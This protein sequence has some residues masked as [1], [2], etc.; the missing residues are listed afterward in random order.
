MKIKFFIL[1]VTTVS[2]SC[3]K[4]Q[5]PSAF[6]SS[7]SDSVKVLGCRGKKYNIRYP[8]KNFSKI[9]T[10]NYTEGFFYAI[11][12]KDSSYLEFHCGSAVQHPLMVKKEYV[13]TD[14]LK[15]S[16]YIKLSGHGANKAL[17]WREDYY[18]FRNVTI[19][20]ANVPAESKA[21]FEKSLNEIR[22]S[23]GKK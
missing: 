18:P 15:E 16:G 7:P 8:S 11:S 14:S 5:Q 6:T 9:S 17:A 2:S 13:V 4:A 1:I 21:A 20:Y 23:I 22:Q 19:V 12:Y 3:L 10:H